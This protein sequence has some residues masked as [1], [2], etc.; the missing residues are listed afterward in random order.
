MNK[1]EIQVTPLL[2]STEMKSNG[3]IVGKLDEHFY[4][5][6]LLL[7]ERKQRLRGNFCCAV[8]THRCV[9]VCVCENHHTDAIPNPLKPEVTARN[10]YF[11][12]NGV[13]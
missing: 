4:I 8:V 10:L 1:V 11:F 7:I 3:N 6:G 5:V 12:Y 9:C 13:C 2:D